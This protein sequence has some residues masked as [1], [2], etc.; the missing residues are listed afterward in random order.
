VIDKHLVRERF[1][2][3]LDTYREHAVIQREMAQ[4]LADLIAGIVPSRQFSRVLEVGSGSG[5][6]TE[7]LLSRCGIETYIANDLV[8]E[9]GNFI[10]AEASKSQVSRFTFL[11]GDI[12]TVDDLPAELDLVASNATLQWLSDIEGFFRRMA[13]SLK[14]GGILAF[15][16][17][18][19][20]N[21]GEIAVIEKAGLAYPSLVDL[22]ALAGRF[23]EPLV[24]REERKRVVFSTP[25][26]VLRHIRKTGVN[27]L[28]RR[29]WTRGNYQR[30]LCRYR[31][32][33]SCE[34]GV[35]LTYTPVYCCFRKRLS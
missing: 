25:D 23:F 7:A 34:D 12:E 22:E 19:A 20:G 13:F 15:S 28:F 16:T 9:S 27:G 1:A 35:Y 33:Y 3:A 4:T 11:A 2:K 26:E 31:E 30:F 18:S 32:A 21:M 5:A 24:L 6:L 29:S 17:F 10:E 8:A 14:P